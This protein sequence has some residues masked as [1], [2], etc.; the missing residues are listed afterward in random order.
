VIS[1]AGY[2]YYD[3]YYNEP[4]PDTQEMF[5]AQAEQAVRDDPKD[6]EKRLA[7]A[8]TYMFASASQMLSPRQPGVDC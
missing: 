2:Y 8:E 3:R 7:L 5:V 6:P 1:F 4:E